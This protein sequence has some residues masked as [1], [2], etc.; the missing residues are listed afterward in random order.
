MKTG[1]IAIIEAY[2][3]SFLRDRPGLALTLLL[4]P[5]I[6][7][8]FAAI[9]GAS[10]RGDID[11]SVSFADLARRP[12]SHAVS[13]AMRQSFDRLS[14]HESA[15]AVEANV[16]DGRADAGVIL[17]DGGPLGLRVEVLAAGG[18]E[19]AADFVAARMAAI[20]AAAVNQGVE[21]GAVQ[22]RRL[23]PA[24]DFPATYY[25]AAVS[26]MFVFFAAV[27]GAM[28]GLDERRSGLQSRLHLATGGLAPVLGAHT[29]P[30]LIGVGYGALADYADVDEL[31]RYE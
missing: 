13:M 4:P 31:Q 14:E 16:I 27:H 20:R 18:R 7:L 21:D 22:R 5:V 11:A 26:V 29:G 17:L 24:G 25:A 19:A 10:G 1:M 28:S 30:G 3:R 8:L 9:F 12:A 6:Y 23:G 15:A 2:A